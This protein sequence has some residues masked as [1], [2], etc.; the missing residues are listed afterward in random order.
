MILRNSNL[1]YL[2]ITL[3]GKNEIIQATSLKVGIKGISLLLDCTPINDFLTLVIKSNS[4]KAE[5]KIFVHL[6]WINKIPGE[7][8]YKAG[9]KFV[10]L[11]KI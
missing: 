5:T 10:N 6:I 4:G 7:D 9:F 8:K 2:N 1:R 11:P 3:E